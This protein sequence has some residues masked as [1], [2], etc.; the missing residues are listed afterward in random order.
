[1]YVIV[2]IIMLK[3]ISKQLSRYL[4]IAYSFGKFDCDNCS[5]KIEIP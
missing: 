5:K 3:T 1:M 4:K 2:T